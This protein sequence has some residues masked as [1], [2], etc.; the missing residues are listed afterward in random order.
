M[1]SIHADVSAKCPSCGEEFDAQAW[2]F[3][4]GD[5]DD[6]LR[7]ALLYGEFNLLNCTSCKT[8]FHHEMPVVYFDPPSELLVFI[9]PSAH[10]TER[11]KWIAKMNEDFSAL[12]GNL[13]REMKMDSPP[14][15][16][17]GA[18]AMRDLLESEQDLNDESDVIAAI[19]GELGFKL[20]KIR[21]SHAR[22][23]GLPLYLPFAGEEYSRESALQAVSETLNG[24]DELARLK[25]LFT[26]LSDKKTD[27]PPLA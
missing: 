27:N 10:E 4:R 2:S 20:K 24:R 17:F 1:P 6:G 7:L 13:L 3:V 12:K 21:P 8:L 19:A 15:V 14:L 25:K 22:G 9:L 5:E 16:L 11:G 23:H 18:A 26:R